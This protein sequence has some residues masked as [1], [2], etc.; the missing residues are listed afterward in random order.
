MAA[1]FSLVVQIIISMDQFFKTHSPLCGGELRGFASGFV[2]I[3]ATS[4][5]KGNSCRGVSSDVFYDFLL[6]ATP[7]L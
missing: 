7:Y 1:L 2:F 6:A 3:D 4:Q 5:G